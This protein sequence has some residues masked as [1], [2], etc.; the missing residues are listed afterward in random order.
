MD[1]AQIRDLAASMGHHPTAGGARV[2]IRLLSRS[3]S[4]LV[5]AAAAHALA[6][7]EALPVDPELCR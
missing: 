2:V 5:V 7:A 6:R 1:I 4:G 3:P